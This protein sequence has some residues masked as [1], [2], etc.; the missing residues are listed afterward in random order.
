M[1]LTDGADRNVIGCGKSGMSVSICAR[2]AVTVRV[3][4]LIFSVLIRNISQLFPV[5]WHGH[6]DSPQSQKKGDL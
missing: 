3:E 5:R 6:G 4:E 1:E 2:V